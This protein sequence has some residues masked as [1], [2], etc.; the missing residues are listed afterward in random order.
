MSEYFD[1]PKIKYEGP[2]SDNPFAFRWYNADE[3]VEGKT[4]RDHFRF[5]VVYWHTF[6]CQGTDPFGGPT[7]VRP[8]ESG[9][10]SVDNAKKR[11][12]VA[13]EF[14][15]KLGVPY[16]A[17]HD[18]DIAP[19]GINLLESNKNLDAVVEVIRQQMNKTGIKLLWGTA[20]LFSNRRYMHGAATSSN[21]D[22]FAFAKAVYL[23]KFGSY[24]LKE[25]A[26]HFSL[27]LYFLSFRQGFSVLR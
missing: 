25:W 6:R 3:V 4:M 24:T 8:W 27:L 7:M 12:E 21:A 20:N 5:S 16:F 23:R 14:M 2:D 10:D 18:R 1:V 19:E 13:F 11:V 17:F 9:I 15:D 26:F 22:V